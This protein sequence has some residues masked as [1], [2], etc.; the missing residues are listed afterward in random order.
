MNKDFTIRLINPEDAPAT[1]DIYRPFVEKTAISFEYEVPSLEEW[2]S[3]IRTYTA[4]YPWLVCE[5]QGRI[6]GYAYGSKHRSRTA[7]D[8]SPESTIYL[9][10]DFHGAGIGR[11]LYETL[12]ELLKLQGYVNVYAGVTVPNAKSEAFHLAMGFYDVGVFKKVGFKFGAW[13][14]TRWFQRHLVAHPPQPTKPKRLEEVRDAP[15]FTA[16]LARK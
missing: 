7:Y 11:M 1:L 8:W 9:A 5:Y 3:R 10:E 14:D 16:I 2:K 6:A 4:D 12:F 15:E 13:H